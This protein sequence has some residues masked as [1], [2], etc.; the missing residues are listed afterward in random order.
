[1]KEKIRR[2][3][4]K[5]DFIRKALVKKLCRI[6]SPLGVQSTYE[7]LL[8]DIDGFLDCPCPVCS[9]S[10]R[11]T[12]ETIVVIEEAMKMVPED[13]EAGVCALIHKLHV[14]R[15]QNFRDIITAL[16]ESAIEQSIPLAGGIVLKSEDLPTE[17]REKL[18]NALRG[19]MGSED[20]NESLE[21]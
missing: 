11:M 8:S 21:N 4:P 6:S 14:S 20:E 9:E 1:M 2:D 12:A 16:A 5:F 13:S 17:L 15:L 10:V 3:E 7:K 18:I 19:H